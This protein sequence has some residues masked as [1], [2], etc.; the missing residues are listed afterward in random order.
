MALFHAEK[1][2]NVATLIM[3]SFTFLILL[4]VVTVSPYS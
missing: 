2:T 4:F 3:L 1:F